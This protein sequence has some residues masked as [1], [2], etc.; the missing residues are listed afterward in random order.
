MSYNHSTVID[1]MSF[2]VYALHGTDFGSVHYMFKLGLCDGMVKLT[3]GGY[4]Q[5]YL[6]V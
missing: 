4:V 6:L 3:G 5:W 1:C 2:L